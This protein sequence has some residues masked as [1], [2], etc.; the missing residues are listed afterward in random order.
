LPK[1]AI[2]LLYPIRNGREDSSLVG[3]GNDQ[4]ISAKLSLAEQKRDG[5]LIPH[6]VKAV[7][8]EGMETVKQPHRRAIRGRNS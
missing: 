7:S 5:I 2:I 4:D 1:C 6:T 8:E 3:L